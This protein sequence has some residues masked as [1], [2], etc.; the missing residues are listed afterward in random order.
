MQWMQKFNPTN[1]NIK[2]LN[3]PPSLKKLQKYGSQMVN[4]F[5][6][7]NRHTERRIPTNNSSSLATSKQA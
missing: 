3:M 6:K 1:E 4:E 7:F 2:E 5:P